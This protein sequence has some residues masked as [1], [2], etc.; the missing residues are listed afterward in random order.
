MRSTRV[1]DLVAVVEVDLDDLG[2]AANDREDVVEVMGDPGGEGAQ[3][4]HFLAMDE[5]L[6]GLFEFACSFRHLKFHLGIAAAELEVTVDGERG[7]EQRHGSPDTHGEE[8]PPFPVPGHDDLE[9]GE[10]LGLGNS[11]SGPGFALRAGVC[12][13]ARSGGRT[14]VWKRTATSFLH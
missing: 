14:W 9:L 8:N 3:G 5:G 2:G 1:E 11:S 13:A 10:E 6:G 7:E 4:V 12:P